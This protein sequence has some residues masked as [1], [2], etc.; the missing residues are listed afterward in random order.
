MSRRVASREHHFSLR[1]NVSI[2]IV[3]AIQLAMS[4]GYEMNTGTSES[5][6]CAQGHK[7]DAG[8]KKK[9]KLQK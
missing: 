6:L 8:T 2:E 4:L 9:Q 3:S 5:L 7:P 1:H